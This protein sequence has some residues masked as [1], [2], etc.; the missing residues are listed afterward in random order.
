MLEL[1]RLLITK[2]S[3]FNCRVLVPGQVFAYPVS[4]N[5]RQIAI[6]IDID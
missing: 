2:K 4:A 1:L 5:K 3:G 6:L